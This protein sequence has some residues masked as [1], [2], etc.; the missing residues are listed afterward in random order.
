MVDIE[1]NITS[2]LSL[3]DKGKHRRIS[4]GNLEAEG[5]ASDSLEESESDKGGS[6]F[7]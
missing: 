7:F 5:G 4:I 6:Y 2:M 1:P 3:G